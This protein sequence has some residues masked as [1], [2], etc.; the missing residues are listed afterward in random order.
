MRLHPAV[1]LLLPHKAQ[2]D[3]QVLSF[4]VPKNSQ[5]FVNVWSMGRDPKYWKKPL[6]F[7]PERF[8]KS[9][10]DYKDRDFEFIPFG[11]RRRICLGMPLAIRMVNLMLASIIQPFNWKLPKGMTPENLD[12]EEQFG[13]TLR[14]A[15]PLVAVPNVEKK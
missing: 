6:E 5:V 3:I 15:I 11:A 4:N 12:M 10:V 1:P 2:H 7:L 8:I 9:S 14:K 13:V